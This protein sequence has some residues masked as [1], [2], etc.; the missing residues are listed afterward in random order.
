VSGSPF[1]YVYEL[2]PPRH[3]QAVTWCP[4]HDDGACEQLLELLLHAGKERAA[5]GKGLDWGR[6]KGSRQQAPAAPPRDG[7]TWGEIRQAIQAD[8]APAGPKGR[9][10]PPSIKTT[11]IVVRL[12]RLIE[13]LLLRQLLDAQ[14]LPDEPRDHWKPQTFSHSF[15]HPRQPDMGYQSQ[16]GLLAFATRLFYAAGR[17]FES[18]RGR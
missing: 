11:A 8:I 17:W 16:Q 10:R 2:T 3:Q 6:L 15:S 7:L 9:D 1:A 13:Q 4:V 18:I 5:G 14:I 12:V